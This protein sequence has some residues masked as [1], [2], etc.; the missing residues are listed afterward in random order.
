ML[1]ATVVILSVCRRYVNEVSLS[2]DAINAVK[3]V[4]NDYSFSLEGL[5][6]TFPS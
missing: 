3:S 6:A 2:L 5:M 4:L 1:R